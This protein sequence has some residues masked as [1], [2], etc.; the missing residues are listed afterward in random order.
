M[1]AA[2]APSSSQNGRAI[3]ERIALQLTSSLDLQV[4]LTT[5]T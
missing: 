3:L 2:S 5:I 1:G 4:V